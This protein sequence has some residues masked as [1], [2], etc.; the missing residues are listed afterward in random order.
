ML[1]GHYPY[2]ALSSV[3]CHHAAIVVHAAGFE[4]DKGRLGAAHSTA[5]THL[6]IHLLVL[7]HLFYD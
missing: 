4:L 2:R 1:V 7:I 3:W 5:H 6:R